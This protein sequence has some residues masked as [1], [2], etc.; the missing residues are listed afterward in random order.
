MHKLLFG[1]AGIPISCGGNT[2]EGV[3]HVR[4]LGLDAM[5]LEF[6]HSVNISE[7][8]ALIVKKA[9]VDNNVVLTCHA[10]YYINLNAQDSAKMKASIQRLITAARVA[11]LCGG[12]SVAFHPGFYMKKSKEE[13]Y[14]TIKENIHVIVETLKQ[15]GND[16]W[17]RPEI[18]GKRSQFGDF[19]ELVNISQE[20]ENVLPCVDYGH[21]H[22]R[23][24][25]FNKTEEF[26][27]VLEKIEKELGKESLGNMH[28]Q[29]A[30]IEYTK[31]GERRHIN[32]EDSDLN[33]LDL[34]QSWK[35]FNI[36]GA[37]I[38]ESPN[39]EGD[40]LM[41]KRLYEMPE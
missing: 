35:D 3:K 26:R 22:A 31:A 25:K 33:F 27:L 23:E 36:K 17:I 29:I 11:W 21:L 32:L 10:P 37:V 30:G 24:G 20:L 41:L 2:S 4:V 15:E 13:T 8:A 34:I 1:T 5:E 9:A 7:K 16:I 18:T 14:K 12:W 19:E 38:S 39:I 28:I 6:V 40:A